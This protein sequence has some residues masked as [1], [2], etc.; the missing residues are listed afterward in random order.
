M[1]L[2]SVTCERAGASELDTLYSKVLRQPGNLELNLRFAQLAEASGYTR[3]ALAAYERAVLNA[4]DNS[5]AL[6][7]LQRIRRKLQPSTTLMTVQIGAQ[8]ESN[9]RYYLPPRRAE[10]QGFGS[11]SLIDERA[12][13]DTRWRTNAFASGI[14]HSHF[15]ELNYAVAGADTGPVLDVLPGW[16]LHP[17]VGGSASRFDHRFYY[18]EGWV[19]AILDSSVGGI[20]RSILVREAYRSYANFFPSSE[21]FYTE[22]RGKLAVPGVLGAGSVGIVSPWALWSNIG[23]TASVVVPVITD[24]QPGAYTE[25]GSKFEIIKAITDKM[26]VGL[27][28]AVSERKYKTDTVIATAQKRH[29][30]FVIPGGSVTFPNLFAYQSDL[31]LEYQ[32]LRDHSNDPTKRFFDHIVTASAVT[33]FD[34]TSPPPWAVPKP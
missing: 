15:N 10:G 8:Y 18:G 6:A 20:Y 24:L 1:V 16:V 2:A 14:M 26:F 31:R 23:G 32:Y 28:I 27:N 3:W 12:F 7:G 21:G 34:P 5:E 22:V 25:W 19:G 4:P 29:D 17:A 11:A 33:R 13:G 9:P 30:R